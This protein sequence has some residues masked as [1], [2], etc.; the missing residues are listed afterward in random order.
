MHIVSIKNLTPMATLIRKE[1]IRISEFIQALS[2]ADWT[3]DELT[4]S[5][6]AIAA[7]ISSSASLVLTGTASYWDA[8]RGFV[9]DEGVIIVYTD[10][11]CETVDG[12]ATYYPA[13]KIGDGNAYVQDIAFIGQ[14]ESEVLAA[15]IAD[16]VAHVTAAERQAWNNKLNVNDSQEV[17]GET[18]VFNRN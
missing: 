17:S 12:T 5:A 16:S 7:R 8:Q 14:H 2:G 18:L 13:I 4:V 10:H 1:Q 9:P 11:Y 6:K 3:S 15:H